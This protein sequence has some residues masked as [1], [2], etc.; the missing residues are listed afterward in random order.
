MYYMLRKLILGIIFAALLIG[1]IGIAR[2]YRFNPIQGTLKPTGILVAASN[3]DGAKIFVDGK[4]SG[5]TNT[6]ISLA[7][8]TYDVEIKKDG[9][10]SW[11]RR[12]TIKGELVVK[13]EA[14]LFPQN[15]TLSPVTSL[16][17][18]AAF[19]SPSGDKIIIVSESGD[20]EE[21][22]LYL[23]ENVRNPLSRINPLNTLVLKS[24]F[25]AQ[26]ADFKLSSISVEFS[27]DEKE[28][29]VTVPSPVI[30]GQ[31]AD[32]TV[33]GTTYL[34]DTNTLSEQ[35]FDVTT[36]LAT[37]QTAWETE[38][39]ELRI[40]TLKAFK[41]PLAKVA[42]SSFDILAFSPDETKILYTATQSATIPQIIKPAL[43]SVNQTPEIRSIEPGNIYVYDAEEDRNY[44]LFK[45]TDFQSTEA[46]RTSIVWYPSSTH[47]ILKEA[48]KISVLDFDG[49]NKRTVYSGPFSPSFLA[50]SKDGR[51]FIMTNF[52]SEA[53]SLHDI[54]SIGLK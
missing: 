45:M 8:G 31:L 17:V 16:G 32:P 49:S 44:A 11:K 54:Y 24:T 1:L 2:G 5:A 41:K 39:S 27:P 15:P 29:L 12:L 3:P 36:S 10:T 6:N 18:T 50:T 19:V 52:N 43:V 46:A 13:V 38:A 25:T 34:I 37:I 7:P 4:L 23:L 21:D 14:L 51:L 26:P 30:E 28:I 20:P 9:F 47:F 42:L 40:K 53:G 48:K 35:L 22:G 33:L